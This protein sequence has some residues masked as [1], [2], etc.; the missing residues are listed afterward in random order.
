MNDFF[1]NIYEQVLYQGKYQL[2]YTAMYENH[3]YIMIGFIFLIVPFIMLA[4]FYFERWM[5]Y[6]KARHWL[7]AIAIG[8]VIVIVSTVSVF[9]LTVLATGNQNL[10]SLL[11]NPDSGYYEHAT[12]IRYYYGFYNVLLAFLVSLIYSALYK[13]FSK[14]HSHLPI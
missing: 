13:R 3:G 10:A 2:V 7:L 6:L 4:L 1:A 12:T 14:L 8:L 9:N 11:A 5:P